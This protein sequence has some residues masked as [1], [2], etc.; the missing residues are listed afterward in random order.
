[1]VEVAEKVIPPGREGSG[2]GLNIKSFWVMGIPMLN[3]G[4]SRDRLI[5]NMDIPIL[6]KLN[7]YIETAHWAPS[8][9]KGNLYEYED[10]QYEDKT[11][12]RPSYLYNGNPYSGKTASYYAVAADDLATQGAMASA[13]MVFT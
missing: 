10:L 9:N 4:W 12:I 7:L 13:A 1:M 8:Q 6:V 11:V 2:P 3:I 5:F